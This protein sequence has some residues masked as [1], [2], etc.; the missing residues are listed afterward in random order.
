MVLCL[1][2]LG[3]CGKWKPCLPQY[4]L[5][6]CNN[7]RDIENTEDIHHLILYENPELPRLWFREACIIRAQWHE[8]DDSSPEY[9][10]SSFFHTKQFLLKFSL[11]G[12]L[13]SGSKYLLP[14]KI[15]ALNFL[16]LQVDFGRKEYAVRYF[17][18]FYFLGCFGVVTDRT[19]LPWTMV[20]YLFPINS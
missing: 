17:S 16:P 12:N 19:V 1:Q 11:K 10:S 7:E 20:K 13:I 14:K 6:N 9:W 18:T 15:K 2:C 8:R 5:N 3:A 4:R